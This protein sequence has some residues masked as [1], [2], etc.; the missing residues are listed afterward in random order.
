MLTSTN[1]TQQFFGLHDPSMIFPLFRRIG[2]AS[3][4]GISNG[5][6]KRVSSAPGDRRLRFYTRIKTWAL[7]SG[8]HTKIIQKTMEN[9]YL[10]R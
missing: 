3:L 6:R 5:E 10:K 7:P 1:K 2:G 8:K 9:H 4:N